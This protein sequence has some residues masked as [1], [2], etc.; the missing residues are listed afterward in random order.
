MIYRDD[1]SLMAHASESP[2]RV[3]TR[4]AR[5]SLRTSLGESGE[6]KEKKVCAQVATLLSLTC[7]RSEKQ[8]K[9]QMATEATTTTPEAF[10]PLN[11]SHRR[12]NPL[13]REWVLCSREFRS[14]S[15]SPV[16]TRQSALQTGLH[17][18]KPR[19]W[20]SN[21]ETGSLVVG[22]FRNDVPRLADLATDPRLEGRLARA[23]RSSNVLIQKLPTIRNHAALTF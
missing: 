19:D 2:T 7:L 4:I 13:K 8:T 15:L 23:C 22:T 9:L 21:D 1:V 11:H 10:D 14:L 17:H 3:G 6:E 18:F 20:R 16:H 5:P 12:W